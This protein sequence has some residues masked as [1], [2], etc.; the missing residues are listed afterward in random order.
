MDSLPVESQG[1]PKITKKEPKNP[2]FCKIEI[3][4]IEREI[5][6]ILVRELCTS[7]R[8]RGEREQ[9][10]SMNREDFNMNHKLDIINM[11]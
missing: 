2:S 11:Y 7:L 4:A 9:K 10:I 6:I 8:M 3:R 1:K 5:E